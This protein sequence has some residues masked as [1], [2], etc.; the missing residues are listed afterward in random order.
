MAQTQIVTILFCDL[1]GSTELLTR[2]GDLRAGKLNK[3]GDAALAYESLL[4]LDPKHVDSLAALQELYEQLGREKDLLRI[5]E[6]RA[7]AVP[8]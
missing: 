5:L 4:E 2:L 3:P 8:D 1:V 7:G 6:A